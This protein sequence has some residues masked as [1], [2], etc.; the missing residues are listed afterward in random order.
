MCTLMQIMTN[1]EFDRT[2]SRRSDAKSVD[3]NF[4]QKTGGEM[5]DR[6]PAVGFEPTT[7]ALRMRCSAV[8][9]TLARNPVFA[10]GCHEVVRIDQC[11]SL[12]VMRP[13]DKPAIVGSK[14]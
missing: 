2:I 7:P 4:L 11:S 13:T 5:S 9:A 8:E 6:E 1:E 12:S 14:S 3:M 10:S